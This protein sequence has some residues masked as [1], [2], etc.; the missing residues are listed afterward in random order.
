MGSFVNE[1]EKR[2]WEAQVAVWLQY[3]TTSSSPQS[4]HPRE[5]TVMKKKM[6]K[7][8]LQLCDK[9]RENLNNTSKYRKKK[10]LYWHEMRHQEPITVNMQMHR[11]TKN[12][13]SSCLTH[14]RAHTHTPTGLSATIWKAEGWGLRAEG[15][16]F[17]VDT[18]W[19]EIQLGKK[20]G[21]SPCHHLNTPEDTSELRKNL[22]GPTG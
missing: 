18:S 9:Y 8:F 5:N 3:S 6:I 21:W 14:A 15:T 16:F 19:Q 2:E 4:S 22:T 7:I 11:N 13:F 1:E 10:S 12:N 17:C 20:G